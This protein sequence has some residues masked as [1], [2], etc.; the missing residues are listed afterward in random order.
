MAC[1]QSHADNLQEHL[2]RL[3]NTLPLPDLRTALLL[4]PLPG[5]RTALLL[6]PLPGLRTALLLLLLL[7]VLL[8]L[9]LSIW[10]VLGSLEQLGCQLLSQLLSVWRLMYE[11]AAG[12][13]DE[14]CSH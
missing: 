8:L 14:G 2:S 3:L 11:A 4:L 12:V 9:V 13:S 7:L 1:H 5:L 10:L 6:L